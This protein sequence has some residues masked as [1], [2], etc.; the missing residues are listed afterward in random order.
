M[1]PQPTTTR[2]VQELAHSDAAARSE[3]SWVALG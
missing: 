1:L 2:V 3:V